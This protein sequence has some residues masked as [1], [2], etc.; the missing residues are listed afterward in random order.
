MRKVRPLDDDL[1][2]FRGQFWRLGGLSRGPGRVLEG[3]GRLLGSL[4]GLLGRQVAQHV[5]VLRG[6]GGLL[7]LSGRLLALAGC[8][9]RP[10]G[11]VSCAIFRGLKSMSLR[12]NGETVLFKKY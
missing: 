6:P 4:L 9:F 1:W 8:L 7:K 10:S 11:T 3:F 2:D 5:G 12:Q